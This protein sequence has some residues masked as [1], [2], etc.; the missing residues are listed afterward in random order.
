METTFARLSDQPNIVEILQG[1][2]LGEA[3]YSGLL[4]K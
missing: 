2:P 1:A 3:W 4:S